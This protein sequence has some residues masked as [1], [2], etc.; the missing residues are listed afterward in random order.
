MTNK[1]DLNNIPNNF[2]VT[3]F[4]NKHKKVITRNGTRKIR[5]KTN[6]KKG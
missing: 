3:Y 6:Q 2:M 1:I 5:D 4:A